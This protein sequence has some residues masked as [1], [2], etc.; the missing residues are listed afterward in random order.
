MMDSMKKIMLVVL[1]FVLWGCASKID[2]QSRMDE[3]F[4]EDM[5]KKFFRKNNYSEYIDYYTPSDVHE[6]GT[7]TLSTTYEYSNA[8]II[9]NVNVAGII[10]AKYYP[11]TVFL[12]EGFFDQARLVYQHT[13]EF[14]NAN[15]AYD[16]YRYLVY[17]YEDRFLTCF[18]SRDLVFYGYCDEF[19]LPG[20]SSKIL[21]MAKSANVK[22]E[23]VVINY[24]SKDVIDYE[25]KQVN[26]FETT[27][28]VNGNIND[29]LIP[30]SDS[31]VE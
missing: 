15:E 6:I 29:F 1:C 27:M 14:L 16:V 26:L 21:Q 31:S 28:P 24:S 4:A 30:S 17:E 8:R 9:M 20:M 12:D 7:D 25:K 23:D 2:I 10:S 22:S 11:E 19:D 5:S 13:S 3:V 18:L